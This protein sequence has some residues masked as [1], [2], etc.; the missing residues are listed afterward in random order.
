MSRTTS[1]KN[2]HIY[3]AVAAFLAS[4]F[5]VSPGYAQGQQGASDQQLARQ[6][7]SVLEEIIVTAQKREQ[8]IQDVGIAITAFSGEQIDQL[9]VEN[10]RDIADLTA[11]V[12][13]TASFG[14]QM[15]LFTIRGVVQNE[16]LDTTESPVAVYIDEAYIPMMQ[17][18][19]FASFDVERVEVLKGPQSTLFGRNATGGLVHFI[20]RK[21]TREFEAFGD[22]SYGEYDHVKLEGAVSGPL[23]DTISG[24]ISGVYKRHDGIYDNQYPSGDPGATIYPF[25]AFGPG[26]VSD[27][28]DTWNDDSWALRGQLLFEPNED[29]SLLVSGFGAET[30]ASVAPG[31]SF[32][33][34]AVFDAQGRWVNSVFSSPTNVCEAIGPGG[35]C[36][37][38]S[39]FD[40]ELPAGSVVFGPPTP[41][42]DGL[43]PVPG[44]DLFGYID[45]DGDGLDV[46]TDIS[47]DD[48]S[49]YKTYGVTAKLTWDFDNFVL[50]SV[51][52]FMSF[53]KLA[54]VDIG[55][56]PTNFASF[57][58][59]VESDTVS[60]ELRINGETERMRWVA[61]FYYLWVDNVTDNGFALM[62]NSPAVFPAGPPPF[63][64]PS[65][66]T[67][68]VNE[69][70]LETN[71]YSAFAQLD[72][73]LTEKLTF[74]A[75]LR[76][77][78]EEQ[79]Y[80]RTISIYANDD[81]FAVDTNTLV[82]PL[83]APFEDSR[84]ST[85]WAG[86][87]QFEYR[88]NDDW[89]IYAGINRGVKAGSY[90][91]KGFPPFL[92]DS[93]IPYDEEVLTSY[94]IGFKSTLFNGTT[95]LNGT[96]FYYDYNDYQAFVFGAVSGVIVN[97][98]AKNKGIELELLTRPID[99][100]ELM[101][102]AAFHDPEVTNL[103]VAPSVFRDVRPSF[104]P[105]AQ[106]AGVARYEFPDTLHGGRLA[107]QMSANY[108]SSFFHNLRNFDGQKMRAYVIG[109]ARVS[110]YSNDEHWEVTGYVKNLA[111]NR[112][113]LLGFEGSTSYGGNTYSHGRPRWAG[114]SLRYSY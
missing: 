27:V 46:S 25:G 42:E 78:I 29:I 102:N 38:I 67:E 92:P 33:T 50:T 69:L 103:E 111:D 62:T 4:V 56:T 45:P 98:D 52:N 35:A 54:V 90:N 43:R 108:N 23:S 12:H 87:L 11:G 51:T 9:G 34:V 17:G 53:D 77:V 55:G 107:V 71:S 32:P 19:M 106:L 84:S 61:G 70:T 86:K 105:L 85:L 89:L 37:P 63:F 16:F 20:S 1:G 65:A 79:D 59:D 41:L 10:S 58:S 110:W 75:G 93:E 113:R 114:V 7:T 100:F 48:A 26:R 66:G 31:T 95:R 15:Q 82:F 24:R 6:R 21:P 76:G 18:Q 47:R 39:G 101:L 74:I 22:V 40:G 99:G 88:P 5:V 73:D 91:A 57:V 104:S 112:Y 13:T 2:T 80:A 64:A 36:V 96:F 60:Q 94:E 81:D 83:R 8:S 28:D 49:K 30:E 97:N 3:S 14:G 44:G 72:Y 109:N 68:Y